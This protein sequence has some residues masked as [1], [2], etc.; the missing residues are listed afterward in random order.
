MKADQQAHCRVAWHQ[1]IDL[2]RAVMYRSI[3]GKRS[4]IRLEHPLS[5]RPCVMF[6]VG[7]T[8]TLKMWEDSDNDGGILTDY[9]GCKI[10]EVDSPRIKYRQARSP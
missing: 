9:A 6:N 10:V 1:A 2:L 3:S 7:A 4:P 8:Y 5:K